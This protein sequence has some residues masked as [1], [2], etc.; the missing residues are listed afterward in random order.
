MLDM[1]VGRQ[2]EAQ[3]KTYGIEKDLYN[4]IIKGCVQKEMRP[5]FQAFLKTRKSW[6]APSLRNGGED[7]Y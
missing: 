7:I 3:R 4:K 5:S 6:K 2:P 1:V